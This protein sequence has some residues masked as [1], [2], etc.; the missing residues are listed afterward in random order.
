MNNERILITGGCG[1]VGSS[2][3]L[4]LRQDFPQ[5][6]ITVLDNLMRKGSELNVSR[7]K[8]NEIRFIQGDV[9]HPEDLKKAGEISLIIDA[10]AEPSVL[11]GIDSSPDYVIHTN[12]NGT[13]NCLNLARENKARFVFLSTSRV[14]PIEQLRKVRY[15]EN[16]ARFLMDKIQNVPGVSEKGIAENFS[17]EGARSFYGTSKLSSEMFIQEYAEFYGVK[18]IVNRCGVI[19]GPHQMGKIDQGVV[20]F[21][22]ARH[23]WKGEL[24]YIGF[25]GS[26]K[27]V[28][29]ILHID[30]LYRLLKIQL[31][32]F[33]TYDGKVYNVGGGMDV[34]VSLKELTTLCENI[35]GNKISI[36]SIKENRSADIPIYIT[37]HSMISHI[38]GW[39]PEKSAVEILTD[40]F[41]WM[42]KEESKI[43]LFLN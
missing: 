6:K 20:V 37:D 31:S 9:R 8:E 11:S 29:D 18:S 15:F 32:D 4:K 35:T 36:N 24:N 25:G 33:E 42:Q 12:L 40:I 7:M 19:A 1:F 17:L 38:S 34:S 2:I 23:F 21:W 10:A 39:K 5:A 30:D 16:D 43:K 14:Y 27:Q 28:R 26:G 22:M 3:A 13:I 41:H